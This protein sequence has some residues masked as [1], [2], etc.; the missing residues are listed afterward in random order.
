MTPVQLGI[1]PRTAPLSSV[2]ATTVANRV[3][4]PPLVHLR[5]PSLRNSATPAAE[6][7]TFKRNVQAFAF[8]SRLNCGRFG[9]FA[10]NCQNGIGGAFAP[11][12]PAMG[13]ALNTSTLPPVKCYRCGGPNHL[14]R[15]CLA[16]PGT[17]AHDNVPTGPAAANINKNKTCY[18]C[19]QEGHQKE[20]Y[21]I[22]ADVASYSKF[23]PFCTGSRTDLSALERAMREK[24]VVD[25]ELTVGFLSLT[26]SYTSVVTSIP[27]KSVQA[28]AA[29]STPLF[30]TLSTTWSF[31]PHRPAGSASA[32]TSS[33]LVSFDL[34]YE[35]ANPLHA[36]V[37]SAFFGQVS[38]TMIRAFEDRCKALYGPS[39]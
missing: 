24:T 5:G 13:R 38:K 35:F 8:S 9:H 29:S 27:F 11:R 6:L 36:G 23:I 32:L 14:A 31:Q 19:Q 18:K 37:S 28:V 39:S 17:I 7:D 10:R 2:C 12:A 15:D 30:K 16:A 22:V 3:M 33:T 1:L 20:L 26:E 4:N 34:T 25:A 21:A